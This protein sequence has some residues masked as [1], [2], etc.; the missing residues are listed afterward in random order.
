MAMSYSGP[1]GKTAAEYYSAVNR[2]ISHIWGAHTPYFTNIEEA[3]QH[4]EQSGILSSLSDPWPLAESVLFQSSVYQGRGVRMG[5]DVLK[6]LIPIADERGIDVSLLQQGLQAWEKSGGKKLA[7][8]RAQL[9]EDSCYAEWNALRDQDCSLARLQSLKFVE[10]KTEEQA[11]RNR[12]IFTD[13]QEPKAVYEF[14]DG[15]LQAWL[16]NA[17]DDKKLIPE[18]VKAQK[19]A[20]KDKYIGTAIACV[21]V[22]G[23]ACAA[24]WAMQKADDH[25]AQRYFDPD[26]VVSNHATGRYLVNTKRGTV[27]DS[28]LPTTVNQPV[29]VYNVFD[30]TQKEVKLNSWGYY[31]ETLSQPVT[32]YKKLG[33]AVAAWNSVQGKIDVNAERLTEIFAREAKLATE[34]QAAR[35]MRQSAVA[36]P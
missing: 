17:G 27:A 16:K 1:K 21:A 34:L 20:Q 25:A 4:H 33:Q 5:V 8:L 9:F 12:F 23:M 29:T 13:P 30:Q 35:E 14:S 18:F 28:P 24:V 26:E 36:R 19:Q 31:S 11:V 6:Q 22:V 32:D 15:Q 3:V 7:S 10:Y 2:V